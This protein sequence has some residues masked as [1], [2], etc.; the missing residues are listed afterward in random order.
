[1][2]DGLVIPVILNAIRPALPVLPP[3]IV[4]V[5]PPLT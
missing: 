1:M 4:T 2:L 5:F 3:V